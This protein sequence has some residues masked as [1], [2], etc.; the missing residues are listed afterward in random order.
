MFISNI[1]YR[2]L[3]R[4]AVAFLVFNP[5]SITLAA[6]AP[7]AEV[8][9]N[10]NAS[11]VE[12]ANA[13]F[14]LLSKTS[15]PTGVVGTTAEQDKAFKALRK[16]YLDPAILV[17]RATGERYTFDTYHPADV[18]KFQ[19]GDLSV[20]APAADVRVVR[21]FVRATETLPDTAIAMSNDKAPRLTVF[22]WSG[23]DSRWKVL[24]HANFNTPIAVICNQKPIVDNN[25]V[26]PASAED[27]VLG[28]NLIGTFYDLL[29][30]GD[31]LPILHPEIQFQSASGIG[32]ARLQNRPAPSKYDGLQFYKPIVTRNGRLLVVSTYT[33]AK[34]RTLMQHNQLRA[35]G[36]P[37]L[38]TFFKSDDGKWSLVAVSSFAVPKALPDGLV[39]VHPGKLDHAP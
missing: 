14:E 32:Y 11:G 35:G 3:C 8:F 37:N 15:S 39:C 22:H 24:S 27:Q 31:A 10:K 9:S 23:A 21:Y 5:S 1:I 26:S 12:L 18:E 13:F 28:E 17:Q 19:I 7:Y 20:T 6:N 25:L 38:S 36:A 30:K 4:A 33:E 29:T 16:S 34:Q 2:K